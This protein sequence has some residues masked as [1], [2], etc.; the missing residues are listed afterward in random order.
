LLRQLVGCPQI[1]VITEGDPFAAGR[2]DTLVPSSALAASRLIAENPDSSIP[3]LLEKLR[4]VV[5]GSLVY[6]DDLEVDSLLREHAC[7]RDAEEPAPI[8]CG[9]NDRDLR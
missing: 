2:L 4:S 9:N 3:R 1:V 7:Q 6:D 5:G 8:M